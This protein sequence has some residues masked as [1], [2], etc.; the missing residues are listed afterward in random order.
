MYVLEIS[1]QTIP[2]PPEQLCAG[3]NL[4]KYAPN[5][6]S[7]QPLQQ[8]KLNPQ[9]HWSRDAQ[10][11]FGQIAWLGNTNSKCFR[12]DLNPIPP[13]PLLWVDKLTSRWLP[14]ISDGAKEPTRLSPPQNCFILFIPLTKRKVIDFPGPSKSSDPSLPLRQLLWIHS[15][16]T[17]TS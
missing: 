10:S 1:G 14:D 17:E 2:H 5:E 7:W 6:I 13:Y 9:Q 8:S 15:K 11:S 4:I 16:W 12:D 3:Q